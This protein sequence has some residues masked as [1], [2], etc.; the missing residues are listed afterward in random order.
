MNKKKKS[1]ATIEFDYDAAIA[2]CNEFTEKYVKIRSY[3]ETVVGLF[4]LL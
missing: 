1:K 2:A 4:Q 3:N